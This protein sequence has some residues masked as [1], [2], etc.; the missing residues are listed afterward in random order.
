MFCFKL[1]FMPCF[2]DKK[3]FTKKNKGVKKI[4]NNFY[5]RYLVR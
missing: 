4:M 2:F 1:L 5:K 3:I